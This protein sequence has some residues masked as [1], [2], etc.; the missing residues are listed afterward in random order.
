MKL[1]EP[2]HSSST[3]ISYFYSKLPWVI[4]S[5]KFGKFAFLI[6][7]EALKINFILRNA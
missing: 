4:I 5:Q 7:S 3:R 6:V 1:E 2:V